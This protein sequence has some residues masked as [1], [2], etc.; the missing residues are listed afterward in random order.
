M[1]LFLDR[2]HL[3]YYNQDI[4]AKSAVQVLFST[5]Q[6]ENAFEK[7]FMT[8]DYFSK[9]NIVLQ[10]AI[11]FFLQNL[12]SLNIKEEGKSRR[13]EILSNLT[14]INKQLAVNG[15]KKIRRNNH[16]FLHSMNNHLTDLALCAAKN[17]DF[18]IN[19]LVHHPFGFGNSFLKVYE[20]KLNI[21]LYP[22]MA[23]KEACDNSDVCFIGADAITKNGGAIVKT[24][25]NSAADICKKSGVPVY[26]CAHSWKYDKDEKSNELLNLKYDR[27]PYTS[28]SV[29][30]Y[31][32]PEKIDSFIT[33]HG[34]FS[35]NNLTNEIKFFNSWMR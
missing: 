25:S 29:Y 13:K 18:T 7:L 10:N 11:S 23:L 28:S 3:N 2:E 24:G 35:P 21:K 6:E 26:V 14:L 19:L 12:T 5:S 32:P 34:I 16:V 31:I 17:N 27:E 8:K 1:E 15:A 22:D 30:E 9:S 20:N 33:E 4:Y